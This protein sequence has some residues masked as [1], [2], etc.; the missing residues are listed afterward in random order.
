MSTTKVKQGKEHN[1]QANVFKIKEEPFAT[2]SNVSFVKMTLATMSDSLPHGARLVV[3]CETRWCGEWC[4]HRSHGDE[5][6][7]VG[8]FLMVCLSVLLSATFRDS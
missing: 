2:Y 6:C 7:D 1:L 5:W 8:L 3:L 4:N